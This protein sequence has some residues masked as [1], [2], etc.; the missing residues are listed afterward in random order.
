M[1]SVSMTPSFPDALALRTLPTRIDL[2]F[3][4]EYPTNTFTVVKV[5][6][7]QA[8]RSGSPPF[9]GQLCLNRQARNWIIACGV[10]ATGHEAEAAFPNQP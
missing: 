9:D 3:D 1:T 5:L 8:D 4:Q 6:M 2:P 10:E 7:S